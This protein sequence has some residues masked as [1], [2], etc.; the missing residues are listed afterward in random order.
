MIEKK[1]LKVDTRLDLTN[2]R[3]NDKHISPLKDIFT[4]MACLTD[5]VL[6]RNTFEPFW[7]EMLKN[8]K[9]VISSRAPIRILHLKDCNLGDTT[10]GNELVDSAKFGSLSS[11]LRTLISGPRGSGSGTVWCMRV[12]RAL[13]ST[14]AHKPFR[15]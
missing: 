2:C 3:L 15:M 5:V 6:S 13:L 10:K 11:Q 9:H 4:K 14:A 7:P 12:S 1:D 8:I